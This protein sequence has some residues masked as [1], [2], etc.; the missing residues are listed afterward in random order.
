M[1]PTKLNFR[2]IVSAGFILFVVL[3]ILLGIFFTRR[4]E[5][6]DFVATLIAV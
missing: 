5:T 3:V 2:E 1:R 6:D 4:I